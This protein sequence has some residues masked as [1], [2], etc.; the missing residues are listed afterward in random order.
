MKNQCNWGHKSA[1]IGQKPEGGNCST[2][3][4]NL[5][6]RSTPHFLSKTVV[7]STNDT[8]STLFL[9]SARKI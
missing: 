8:N 5:E 1:P 2:T 4:N 3:V 7:R 9:V 6:G